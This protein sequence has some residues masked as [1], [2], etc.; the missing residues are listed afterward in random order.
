MQS[1]CR[2]KAQESPSLQ[3]TKRRRGPTGRP[4]QSGRPSASNFSFSQFTTAIVATAL[5]GSKLPYSPFA[6]VAC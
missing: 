1:A 2:S 6:H 5:S 4:V 3:N